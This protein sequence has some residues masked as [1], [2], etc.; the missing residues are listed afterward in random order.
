MLIERLKKSLCLCVFLLLPVFIFPQTAQRIEGLLASNAIN[1]GQLAQFVLEAAE[2]PGV[3][4]P[5]LAFQYAQQRNWLPS[6]ATVGQPARLRGLSLLVMQA[7]EIQG[8]IFY[9]LFGSPHYA[10]RELVYRNIIVGRSDPGM[11]VSGDT[12]LYVVG[13]VLSLQE[14]NI[15]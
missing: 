1:Y 10:Y 4:S 13:R 11:L 6:N 15:L 9:S 2:I 14:S 3:G 5:E 8:G 7:F 12:L